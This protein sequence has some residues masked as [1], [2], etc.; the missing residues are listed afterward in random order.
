MESE[1]IDT[2]RIKYVD[3]CEIKEAV[4]YSLSRSYYQ[5]QINNEQLCNIDSEPIEIETLHARSITTDHVNFVILGVRI[6]IILLFVFSTLTLMYIWSIILIYMYRNTNGLI[7]NIAKKESSTINTKKG[8]DSYDVTEYVIQKGENVHLPVSPS[9]PFGFGDNNY[10]KACRLSELI[11]TLINE[12]MNEWY[13]KVTVGDDKIKRWHPYLLMND[14]ELSGYI[15]IR[16]MNTHIKEDLTRGM[17]EYIAVILSSAIFH[18]LLR[19]PKQIMDD[20]YHLYTIKLP[21]N[22][23]SLYKIKRLRSYDDM[24]LKLAYDNHKINVQ[25][26]ADERAKVVHFDKQ[27]EVDKVRIYN[28]EMKKL[29]LNVLS[30]IDW[31]PVLNELVSNYMGYDVEESESDYCL[32]PRHDSVETDE[33]YR[34]SFL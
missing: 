4:Y 32:S 9:L 6:V 19:G 20:L 16:I 34:R 14:I 29:V 23:V 21:M 18:G 11:I 10:K 8:L 27:L 12:N 1:T 28:D 15:M 13:T 2:E 26:W 30:E 3:V 7:G 31:N 17:M 22:C 33:D 24:T 5:E 25:R